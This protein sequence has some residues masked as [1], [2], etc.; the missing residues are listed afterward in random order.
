MSS[1][2][3][4]ASRRGAGG[5]RAAEEDKDDS[6]TV[7]LV[8]LNASS[9]KKLKDS[10]R[11][12]VKTK[13][14]RT[15][16]DSDDADSG[17]DSEDEKD[18]DEYVRRYKASN[19]PSDLT[20]EGLDSIWVCFRPCLPC[21]RV[22]GNYKNRTF[23]QEGFKKL[24]EMARERIRQ[25]QM[26]AA[27]TKQVRKDKKA[28]VETVK[29][30]VAQSRSDAEIAAII[31]DMV[32]KW[33]ELTTELSVTQAEIDEKTDLLKIADKSLI[34]RSQKSSTEG[35]G[36]FIA[37]L[38]SETRVTD[39]SEQIDGIR[40]RFTEH[41]QK[42]LAASRTQRTTQDLQHAIAI[43]I[44]EAKG[45]KPA[46]SQEE[47]KKSV[48]SD[49]ERES[50]ERVVQSL[51]AINR[52]AAAASSL[53]LLA[54]SI[55]VSEREPIMIGGGRGEL[56]SPLDPPAGAVGQGLGGFQARSRGAGRPL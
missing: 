33:V 30:L 17:E 54:S 15:D 44:Q 31:T 23:L 14:R 45:T 29:K 3:S 50:D 28:L 49:S 48:E 26:C 25:Q 18:D 7:Q 1:S 2:S 42:A 20:I 39:N 27:L 12:K 24:R 47:T 36:E 13:T 35:V 32:Q 34:A 41:N 4:S 5:S 56:R 9:D 8:R 11:S 51:Q 38:Q 52:S 37:Q 22:I 55:V 10:K 16:S 40:Q 43:I 46:S 21:F 6:D 19:I 53:D